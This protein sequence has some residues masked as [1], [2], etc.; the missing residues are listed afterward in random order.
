MKLPKLPK[1]LAF[2][3]RCKAA[4]KAGLPNKKVV[5]FGLIALLI[6]G[7][8]FFV[9]KKNKPKSDE[10]PQAAKFQT[11]SEEIAKD[12]DNDGLKD[13]EEVLWKT[14]PKNPDTDGDGTSDS[15]EIKENRNPLA[16]GPD[17]K[18]SKESGTGGE[19][20][21]LSPES[22]L[23]L[24]E[25]MGR[26]FLSQYLLLKEEKGGGEIS[27]TDKNALLE[28]FMGGFGQLA[29]SENF[30][31]RN[32]RYTQSDIKLSAISDEN[33]IKEYGNGLALILKKYFDPIPES[34]M[35]VLKKALALQSEAEIK[36]LGPIADA[37]RDSAKEAL[38]LKAP[39][40]YSDFHL[41][42]INEF[43]N[44]AEEL[45]ALEKTFSDPAQS[46][47]ALK[48]YHED[49]LVAYFILI[50]IN[51]YFST[52]KV[53]FNPGEPG[54]YFKVYLPEENNT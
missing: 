24:T 2:L 49:S 25:V 46:M 52:F 7:G 48:Q 41:A 17:D 21:S 8:V 42:L 5:L 22:S 23:T 11:A 32:N 47:L 18:L 6:A 13:W 33:S 38:S 51:A 34:E 39:P 36:K 54:E 9:F 14:N 1:L 26:Q 16:K 27:E 50:N 12:S 43:Y 28:S 40:N 20:S 4:L 15:Q 45:D 53:V 10:S 31:N 3:S 30:E 29:S 44:I 19:N 35:T 37:Y